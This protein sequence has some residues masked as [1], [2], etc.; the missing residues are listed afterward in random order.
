MHVH[1]TSLLFP[2][3]CKYLYVMITVYIAKKILHR[4]GSQNNIYNSIQGVNFSPL[5]I[6]V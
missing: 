6:S 3:Y 1:F 4:V 5:G 2:F